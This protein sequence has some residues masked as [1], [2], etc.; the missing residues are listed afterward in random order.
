MCKTQYTYSTMCDSTKYAGS[1]LNYCYNL[2]VSYSYNQ[3]T[4]FN[5]NTHYKQ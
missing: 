1:V 2:T 5:K 3:L 4:Q